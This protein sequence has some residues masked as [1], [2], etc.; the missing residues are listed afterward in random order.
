MNAY[1]V[2]AQLIVNRR[3]TVIGLLSEVLAGLALGHLVAV[4]DAGGVVGAR[5]WVQ[6]TQLAADQADPRAGVA[7]PR[8]LPEPLPGGRPLGGAA[9][10]DAL[11]RRAADCEQT[12]H[13]QRTEHLPVQGTGL[14]LQ[15]DGRHTA[16]VTEHCVRISGQRSW[17]TGHGA[18]V[19]V[20]GHRS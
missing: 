1:Y 12:R 14:N 2:P 16:R 5:H 8:A 9:E 6:V 10:R 3:L 13:S 18:R 20:T 11:R 17:I 19:R 4:G 7:A 15:S